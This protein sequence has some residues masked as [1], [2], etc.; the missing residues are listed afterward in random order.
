MLHTSKV[1][2]I[3]PVYNDEE[4][5]S[6]CIESVLIQTY[7]NLEII[8]VDD[9]ST[10]NSGKLCDEYEQRDSRICVIHQKNSGVSCAR[11]TA[12]D[13]VTGE[14]LLFVDSDDIVNKY[15]VEICLSVIQETD[16]DMVIYPYQKFFRAGEL[17]FDADEKNIKSKIRKE[18]MDK[19][20]VFVEV[21]KG[22]GSVQKFRMLACNK[23]YNAKLL[24]NIKFPEGRK[25]GEDAAVT[26]RIIKNMKKAVWLEDAVLY[27]YRCNPNSAL[28]KKISKDNLQ[29]F[30]TYNE[31]YLD[32]AENSP[33]YLSLVI[34][35]YVIRMF[36]FSARITKELTHKKEQL[37]C[38]NELE[39]VTMIRLKDICRC[40]HITMK[41]KILLFVFFVSRKAFNKLYKLI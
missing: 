24:Q 25:Y 22:R 21:F 19:Q 16:A 37:E 2:I 13:K 35:A 4:Y 17:L 29:L 40:P 18:F 12:L 38:L 3:I 34:Y 41:Q 7:T 28:N 39:K 15:L 1:S 26:Y 10:D 20:D 31:I 5:L 23:M 8:M 32:I 11:N 27:Y 36:D 14:Y 33:E 6:E 9:G 30:D